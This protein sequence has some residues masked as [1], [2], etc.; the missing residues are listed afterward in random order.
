MKVKI[1]KPFSGPGNREF[2][3]GEVVDLE[4]RNVET[5][6]KHRYCEPVKGSK[7]DN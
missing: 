5:L 1:L 4:G 6:I 3:S 7:K 2:K